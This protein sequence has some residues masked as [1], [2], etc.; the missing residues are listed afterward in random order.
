MVREREV[1][2]SVGYHSL[3]CLTHFYK[4]RKC[5]Y[6]CIRPCST[7]SDK[8]Y[9]AATSLPLECSACAERRVVMVPGAWTRSVF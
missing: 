8:Q 7:W 3:P 5:F 4:K 6:T 2:G 1:P 9:W